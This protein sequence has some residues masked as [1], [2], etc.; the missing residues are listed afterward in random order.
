MGRLDGKVAVVTGN[1]SG[2]GNATAWLL[3]REGAKVVMGARRTERGEKM[4]KEMRAEG[5]EAIYVKTDVM[6]KDDCKNLIRKAVDKYGRIDIL[7]NVAG[8][9]GGTRYKLHEADEEMR[10]RL[11]KTDLYGI[12]D[13]CSEA[14]P[15]MLKQKSGSIINVASVAGIVACPYDSLYS[16]VKGAVKMLSIGMAYDYA[17]DGIRVN[18]V[19]PGLTKTE[20]GAKP[21]ADTAAGMPAGTPGNANAGASGDTLNNGSNDNPGESHGD[22]GFADRILANLPAGRFAQPVEIAQ[23]ILFLASDDASFA[24]GTV[25]TLDGGEIIS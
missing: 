25:L 18:C 15:H 9:N 1:T 13:L 8:I 17:K 23:G 5:L 3:A 16:A 22:T 20:M 11:F 6:I 4:E 2:I 19:C 14:I 7:A 24:N 12:I 10:E 21:P